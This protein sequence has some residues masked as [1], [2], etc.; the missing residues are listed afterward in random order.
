VEAADQVGSK[1]N[2]SVLYSGGADRGSV[3][4]LSP[5]TKRAGTSEIGQ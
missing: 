4:L 1:D 3:G 5:P 2:A